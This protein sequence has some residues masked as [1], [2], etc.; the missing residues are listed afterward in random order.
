MGDASALDIFEDALFAVF[1]HH[2]PARGDPGASAV[3]EHAQLPDWCVVDGRRAIPYRIA[4]LSSAN[5]KLFAHYQW[6][7][8]VHLADLIVEHTSARDGSAADVHGKC[9]V[10]LGAGT[11]VPSLVSAALGAAMTVATDYP[12]ADVLQNMAHNA[13]VLAAL[14]RAPTLALRT[15]GLQWGAAG[16]EQRVAQSSVHAGAYELVIAADV[17]WVSSQH[18]AL[19]HS[20]EA[21]LARREGARFVLVVGFHTGRPAITRFLRRAY[22]SGLVPDVDA[23]YGGVVCAGRRGG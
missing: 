1:E 19:L 12:D 23:E 22:A 17:L 6:D 15:A 7:A 18:E 16:D 4:S 20:V 10:E 21:L 3:Y 8:G 2:Q 9:V 13:A 14:P 5:T 11:A